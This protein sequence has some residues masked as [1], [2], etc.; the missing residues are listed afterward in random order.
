MMR[1]VRSLGALLAVA[2]GLAAHA[3]HAA[4]KDLPTRVEREIVAYTI[5]PDGSYTE[6]REQA[7]KVLKES[8]LESAKS[9]SVSYSTSIQKTEAVE[10]YTLKADGR[11]I[12]VP[13]G[14]FQVDSSA[15]QN[16]DSPFYSDQTR[17][18]VV[19]PDLAVGD[20]IV[21]SYRLVAS[22]PMF[23]NQRPPFEPHFFDFDDDIYGEEI[24]VA[25]ISHIRGQKVFSGLDELIA[26][27]AADSDRARQVLAVS[28]P[29]GELD[30]RLGF[31][32]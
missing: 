10:A 15:G 25:L 29:M 31:F 5:N 2:A 23:D 19:F 26:A 1:M 11:R 24:A 32:A 27:I 12:P 28:R 13:A 3:A 20:T 14:N 6:S 4:G 17:L 30:Q 22:K 7:I 9:A 16:G 8:A 18:T 21:F